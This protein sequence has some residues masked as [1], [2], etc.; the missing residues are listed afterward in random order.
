MMLLDGIDVARVR[1]P[2]PW[3]PKVRTAA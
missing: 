2:E 1:R 3:R